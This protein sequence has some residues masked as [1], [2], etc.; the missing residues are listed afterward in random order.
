[1]VLKMLTETLSKIFFSVI[2]QYSVLSSYWLQANL[3][4]CSGSQVTSVYNFRVM[5]NFL[6]MFSTDSCRITEKFSELLG[7]TTEERNTFA[8][9]FSTT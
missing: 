3:L 7:D 6:K 4:R 1:M 5:D 2:G 8:L 9:N